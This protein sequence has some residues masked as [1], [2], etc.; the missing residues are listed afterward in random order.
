MLRAITLHQPWAWAVLVL[1]KR[2]E[3]RTWKPSRRQLV[4]MDP[5]VIHAGM[6]VDRKGLSWL[7]MAQ[8]ERRLPEADWDVHIPSA[9]DFYRENMGRLTDRGAVVGVV[10]YRGVIQSSRDPYFVGPFGWLLEDRIPLCSTVPARGAQGLWKLSV[11]LER[12]VRLRWEEAQ[13]RSGSPS[14][15]R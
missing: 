2:V 7:K 5:L 6:T 4:P 14:D 1:S 9:D 15:R 8:A 12:N 13:L 11:A 3:N 10:S